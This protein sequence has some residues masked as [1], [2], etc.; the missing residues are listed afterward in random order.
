MVEKAEMLLR[1]KQQI[2][3]GC[4][5][6]LEVPERRVYWEGKPLPVTAQ[7][8][9]LLQVFLQAP[10]EVLSRESIFKQAWHDDDIGRSRTVDVHVQRLRKKLGEIGNIETVYNQGYRF[11]F[12]GKLQ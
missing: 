7:E 4:G 1:K 2:A 8:F 12:P 9:A 11:A 10:G 3:L 5:F 6:E